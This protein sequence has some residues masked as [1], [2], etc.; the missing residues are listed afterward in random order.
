MIGFRKKAKKKILAFHIMGN[1]LRKV[2]VLFPHY[3]NT[4][5]KVLILLTTYSRVP[6]T[7][8]CQ[9]HFHVGRA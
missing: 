4:W 6:I 1:T 2:C 5:H 9:C 8:S 7:L 3:D